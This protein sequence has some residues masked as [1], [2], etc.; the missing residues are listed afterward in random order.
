MVTQADKDR[1]RLKKQFQA[2]VRKIKTKK[3]KN[4]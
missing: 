2:M 4:K 1:E 3:T